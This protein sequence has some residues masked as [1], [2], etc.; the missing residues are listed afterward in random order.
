[1]MRK[2]LS[3]SLGDWGFSRKTPINSYTGRVEGAHGHRPM[4][5]VVVVVQ[6][7]FQLHE[8]ISA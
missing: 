5:L 6:V 1:M 2:K 3:D 8:R 4:W 7:R